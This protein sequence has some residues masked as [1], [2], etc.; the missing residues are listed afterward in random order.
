MAGGSDVDGALYTQP[1]SSPVPTAYHGPLAVV[2]LV[3]G[4]V[5]AASSCSSKS[6]PRG[7]APTMLETACGII[8]SLALGWGALFLLLWAGVWV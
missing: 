4:F 1:L 7:V 3:I 2:L 8:A 5:V 6:T